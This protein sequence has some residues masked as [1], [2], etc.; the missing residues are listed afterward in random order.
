MADRLNP[1]YCALTMV[2]LAVPSRGSEAGTRPWPNTD[3]TF[4]SP[5]RS[6]RRPAL[7]TPRPLPASH[8]SVRGLPIAACLGAVACGGS[9]TGPSNSGGGSSD[10][11]T[12][13]GGTTASCRT[14]A[15]STRSVQTFVTGVVVTT[16]SSCTFNAGTN[17]VGCQMTFMDSV[18]GPGTGTQTTR[19]ASRSDLV[20]EV[21]VVPPVSRAL[22]TTTVTSAA[23][24]SLTTTATHTYDGQR[25][26]M[27]TQVVTTPI[28]VIGSLTTTTTF[29]SW[30]ASGRP[31]AGAATGAGG[32]TVTISYDNTN[33]TVT[34]NT[35]PNTCTHTY[36]QNGVILREVCTGTTASTTVVTVNSTQ[37][38]CK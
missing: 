17:E 12:S 4:L 11:G 23:G 13:G 15:T 6:Q 2:E 19:F 21:A 5:W 24:L 26:L 31:T 30:D 16:D 27:S 29:S 35:G 28:P 8:I 33:R 1:A 14:A 7:K 20:D 22:G 36:D 38:V 3:G 25:R 9:P 37:Q 18:G 10:G 32:S 34:Q